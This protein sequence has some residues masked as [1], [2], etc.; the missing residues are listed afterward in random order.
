[1]FG[2]LSVSIPVKYSYGIPKLWVPSKN[3][4]KAKNVLPTSTFHN[5]NS[6]TYLCRKAFEN[7]L[8]GH[9]V[10]DIYAKFRYGYFSHV[11]DG[12]SHRNAIS[13]LKRGAMAHY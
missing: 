8:L 2:I 13:R 4:D 1:M 7:E 6:L 11:T 3:R 9:R 12:F 10:F 5:S